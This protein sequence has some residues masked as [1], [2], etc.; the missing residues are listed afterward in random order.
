MYNVQSTMYQVT[1]LVEFMSYYEFLLCTSYLVPGTWYTPYFCN[2]FWKL[3]FLRFQPAGN[4][5]MSFS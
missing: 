4:F 3:S 2:N 5:A 1:F